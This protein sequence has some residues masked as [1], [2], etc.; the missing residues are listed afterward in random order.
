MVYHYTTIDVLALVLRNK[1]L[2]FRNANLLD[3]D[4]ECLTIDSGSFKNNVFVS[5]WTDDEKENIALWTMY[6]KNM[7]G[8]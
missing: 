5:C 1:T 3:D 2:R 4:N 8:I 7:K 6:S